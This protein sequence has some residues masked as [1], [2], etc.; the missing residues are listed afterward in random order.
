MDDF[1]PL[2][3]TEH[4]LRWLTD[5]PYAAIRSIVEEILKE[6]VANSS[7]VEFRVTSEPQWLTGARPHNTDKTKSILVRTGVA[8]EFTLTV[9]SPGHSEELSGVFTWVGV[10][11]DQPGKHKQRRWMDIGGTLATFGSTGELK[12]RVY[13]ERLGLEGYS[14]PWPPP[15]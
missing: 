7:P 5:E 4:M 13:L 15:G 10:H 1:T 11:L 2:K 12:T 14:G 9:D 8:F 6:Q 3:K